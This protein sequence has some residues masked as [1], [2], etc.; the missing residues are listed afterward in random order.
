MTK[1]EMFIDYFE[2]GGKTWYSASDILKEIGYS[3]ARGGKVS[4]L[5][6]SYPNKIIRSLMPRM[7]EPCGTLWWDKD[8]IIRLRNHL[9]NNNVITANRVKISKLDKVAEY[10]EDRLGKEDKVLT[11][12]SLNT[13]PKKKPIKTVEEVEVAAPNP[14]TGVLAENLRLQRTVTKL[15]KELSEAK[16]L[17]A[18]LEGELSTKSDDTFVEKFGETKQE[19]YVNLLKR[20]IELETQ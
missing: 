6:P 5:L 14:V 11:K 4:V 2:E 9:N 8:T 13:K 17:I 15:E 20:C 7:V 18:E 12:P 10:I 3:V 19:L 1:K 16:T